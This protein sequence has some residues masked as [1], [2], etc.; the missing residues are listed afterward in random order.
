MLPGSI[1]VWNPEAQKWDILDKPR[2]VPFLTFGGW[3]GAVSKSATDTKRAWSYLAWYA[4]PEHSI[5]DVLDGTSGIESIGRIT[6][7]SLPI[8]A[9][10]WWQNTLEIPVYPTSF[11]S[12]P[13]VF[14]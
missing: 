7:T 13:R 3:I 12:T 11:Y 8:K 10:N 14:S 1:E 4:N 9:E 2:S 6:A 5:N